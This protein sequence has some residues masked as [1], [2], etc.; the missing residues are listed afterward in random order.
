[1]SLLILYPY[2]YTTFKKKDFWHFYTLLSPI[3]YLTGGEEVFLHVEIV[4]I[5]TTVVRLESREVEFL[6]PISNIWTVATSSLVYGPNNIAVHGLHSYTN[7]VY[8]PY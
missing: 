8:E 2:T 5:S 3:Y 1:M 4:Q 6:G 7:T